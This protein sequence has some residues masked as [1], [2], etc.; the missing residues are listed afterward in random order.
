MTMAKMNGKGKET[1][2]E[3]NKDVEMPGA[4]EDLRGR[5]TLVNHPFSPFIFISRPF[6]I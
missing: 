2:I 3:S 6:S 5:S 1:A 4:V